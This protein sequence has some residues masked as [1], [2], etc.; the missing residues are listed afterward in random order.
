MRVKGLSVVDVS[1]DCESILVCC[2]C[3]S[4]RSRLWPQAS[5]FGLR[6]PS[7]SRA[8]FHR[9]HHLLTPQPGDTTCSPGCAASI[10]QSHLLFVRTLASKL[11]CLLDLK[12]KNYLCTLRSLFRQTLLRQFFLIY[13]CLIGVTFNFVM[14]SCPMKWFNVILSFDLLKSYPHH[15]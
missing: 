13:C 2:G 15:K 9:C 11:L 14:Q 7:D 3:S 12:K 5:Y 4:Q 1:L 8:M 10:N 6:P